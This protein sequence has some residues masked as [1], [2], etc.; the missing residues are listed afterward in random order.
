MED[1]SKENFLAATEILGINVNFCSPLFQ[2]RGASLPFSSPL[3]SNLSS[4]SAKHLQM[5]RSVPYSSVVS[6]IFGSL[7]SSHVDENLEV[8]KYP[9]LNKQQ[10]KSIL[11]L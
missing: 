7:N 5:V 6:A 8:S 9:R 11:G 3:L 4:N 2:G 1:K 10:W